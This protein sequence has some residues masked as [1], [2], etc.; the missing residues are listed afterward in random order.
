MGIV[1]SR[2]YAPRLGC[3]RQLGASVCASHARVAHPP[4]KQATLSNSTV[5]LQRF[6]LALS[7]PCIRNSNCDFYTNERQEGNSSSPHAA[8]ATVS[9][10]LPWGSCACLRRPTSSILLFSGI[11]IYTFCMVLGLSVKSYA[12]YALLSPPQKK[13]R[14]H[15]G[16]HILSI[17]GARHAGGTGKDNIQ[18]GLALQRRKQ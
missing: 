11:Q 5:T 9:A 12:S 6:L 7:V 17:R 10:A 1:E 18:V 16:E 8:A 3:K 15:K 14:K 13:L 2:G 4:T